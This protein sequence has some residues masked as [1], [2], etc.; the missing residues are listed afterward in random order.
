[1]NKKELRILFNEKRN[2]LTHSQK[3]K[4]D[5]L[6]LI[7]FQRFHLPYYEF[8]LSFWPMDDRNE[9]NTHPITD[10]LYFQNPGLQLAYPVT[11]FSTHEMKA[12]AVNDETEFKEN[13][14]SIL[15]P[16]SGEI[17]APDEIDVILMPLLAFDKKGYR[18][19]YGKGFYDR[20]LSKCRDE[21]IKI[22]MSYFEPVDEISDVSVHD[23]KMNYCVTPEQIYEFN[24]L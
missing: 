13:K 14:Y 17:I 11:D 22:G 8:L 24:G 6:I 16:V 7:K 18:V 23:I 19:G 20:Y 5:D 10:F 9:I 2:Q 15:E 1:M 12:I 4:F 3:E 21:V